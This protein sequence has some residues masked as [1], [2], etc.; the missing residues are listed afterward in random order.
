MIGKSITKAFRFA[1]LAAA[2][3]L[4]LTAGGRADIVY[5]G[6]Q[7]ITLLPRSPADN[8]GVIFTGGS[9]QIVIV[10]RKP[11]LTAV[12]AAEGND[13]GEFVEQSNIVSA[14]VAGTPINSSST[15]GLSDPSYDLTTS[16]SSGGWRGAQD[17]YMGVTFTEGGSTYYG[18]IELSV[19]T[20]IDATILGWAYQNTPGVGILAGDTGVQSVPEPSTMVMAATALGAFTLVAYRRRRAAAKSLPVA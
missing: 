1:V 14:L 2:L 17:E 16:A 6:Q 15:Y 19:A 12:L 8:Y 7:D 13:V 3:V 9:A 20:N 11:S 5:S 18:W 10:D 4:G